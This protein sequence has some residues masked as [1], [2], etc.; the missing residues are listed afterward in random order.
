[1]FV[2]N[3]SCICSLSF[4]WVISNLLYF[5]LLV[6][7]AYLISINLKLTPY[8][9]LVGMKDPYIKSLLLTTHFRLVLRLR[10]CNSL[11]L[12]PQ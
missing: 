9:L 3:Y 4:V 7:L 11:P 6:S 10:I 1:M 12:Y 8:M 2:F 5:V